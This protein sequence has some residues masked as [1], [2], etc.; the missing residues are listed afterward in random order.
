MDRRIAA[1]V[2]GGRAV[3]AAAPASQEHH[4]N[5]AERTLHF[6]KYLPVGPAGKW[7]QTAV[8]AP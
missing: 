1:C 8:M 7:L 6:A 2:S 4:P 5:Y 3:A